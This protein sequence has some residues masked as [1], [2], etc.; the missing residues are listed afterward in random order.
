MRSR[1]DYT[2]LQA[3]HSVL[4]DR[5]HEA[6]TRGGPIGIEHNAQKAVAKEPRTKTCVR[7]QVEPGASGNGG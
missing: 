7:I 5:N 3:P 1:M 4:N 6:S 2:R